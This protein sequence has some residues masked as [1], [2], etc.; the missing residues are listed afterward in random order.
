[1]VQELGPQIRTISDETHRKVHSLLTDH[2]NKL[3]KAMQQR[4]YDGRAN[5]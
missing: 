2:E 1:M 4:E 5:R 3:E